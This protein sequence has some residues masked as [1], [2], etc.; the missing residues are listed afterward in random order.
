[1]ATASGID[2]QIGF[3]AEGTFGTYQTPT[4]FLELVEES[5]KLDRSRIESMGIRA[6]RRVMH[7]WA[8]GTQ[9]VEGDFS[10]ELAPQ[11]TGLL[12]EH[13]FGGKATSGAGPYT[14]TFTPGAIDGKSLTIQVG[15]PDIAGTVRP[16]SYLGCKITGWEIASAIDEY[17]SGKFSVYGTHEDRVSAL[18]TAS[19]PS[20]YAPFVFTHGSLTVAAAEIPVK[21]FSIKGD[22]GL[23]TDRH[24]HSATTP[25]R[26]RA[27]LESNR[28]EYSGQFV[29]DFESLTQ[30][31]RYV[32]GTEAA[33][34]ITLT[35]G[36][37]ASLTITCNT[38]FDGETPN[39]GGIE[40]P[41]L[42]VPFVCTSG[43]SDAAAITAV[44]VNSDATA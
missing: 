5:L 3:A 2:A 35:Q 18:A 31:E 37:G 25:E 12:L 19:Y 1:M 20:G 43:T 44:L 42:T 26:P 16:F 22:N 7:R 28:R 29:A 11:G 6:G 9:R 4:R 17:V 33:L 30:Y 15:R 10:V 36:A 41:E 24:R 23:L 40:I 32:N 14:H 39:I 38:R 8:P 34:V 21:S 13:A 27:S